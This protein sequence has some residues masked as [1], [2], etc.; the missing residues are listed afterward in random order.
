M[1][2]RFVYT[3]YLYSRRRNLSQHFLIS[4]ALTFLYIYL[5]FLSLAKLVCLLNRVS[6]IDLFMRYKFFVFGIILVGFFGSQFYSAQIVK[7]VRNGKRNIK[8]VNL[9]YIW[10]LMTI[11]VIVFFF[12]M[13]Y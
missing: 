11:S 12:I 10:T 9:E 6:F 8:K 7:N 3:L 4:G 13:I 2:A 5:N 1:I